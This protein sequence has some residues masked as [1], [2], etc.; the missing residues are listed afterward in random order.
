MRE[1]PQAEAELVGISCN[2]T[3][4]SGQAHLLSK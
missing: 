1:M 2:P 3:P 4:L